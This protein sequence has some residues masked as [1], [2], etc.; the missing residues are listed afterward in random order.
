MTAACDLSL[1]EAAGALARGE[2]TA[3]ELVASCLDRIGARQSTLNAF[4]DVRR[5]RALAA[6]ARSDAERGRTRDLGPLSGIPLAHKDMFFRTGEV[7]TCGSRILT[8][9]RPTVTASALERLDAAGALDLGTLHMSEFA[10]GPAGQNAHFGH[11][12]NP[13]DPARISGGSSS[14][15]GA[16]VAAGMVFGALGSDTAGSVRLPAAIC[17]VVGL[18]PTN[19]RVSLYGAMPLSASLDTVG[20]LARRVADCALLFDA[21]AGPDSRDPRSSALPHRLCTPSAIP[22]SLSG[23]RIGRPVDYYFDGLDADVAALAE[24]ALDTLSHLGAECVEVDIPDH[25]PVADAASIIITC[26]A[27]ALHA[28]WLAKRPEDYGV[29]VRE[30]IEAGFG[31]SAPDYLRVLS[32]RGRRVEHIAEHVFGLCD[33]VVAPVLDIGVPTIAEVDVAGGPDSLRTISRLNRKTRT[34][35]YLG[36]PALAVPA[37]KDARGMPVSVQFIGRP[38]DEPLLFRV[39]AAFEDARAFSGMPV[40]A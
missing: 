10:L 36:F 37:G 3:G 9:H 16:A 13:H 31:H 25:E 4:I 24:A 30:R 38:Y 11:C 20:V 28:E 7:S 29:P 1:V 26:E 8:G 39:A 21:I 18:K 27:A 35:N 14:G 2:I 32:D 17:G 34:I 22:D 5:E 12:R 23:L 40:S 33:V 19:G 15:P 6:A